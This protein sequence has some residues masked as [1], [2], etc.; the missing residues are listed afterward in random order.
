MVFRQQ[1]AAIAAWHRA[2]RHVPRGSFSLPDLRATR[3]A[4]AIT[5]VGVLVYQGVTTAEIDEPV[6]QLALGLDADVVHIAPTLD[7][8]VGVEPVRTV[9]V[10]VTSDD[11]VALRS[12]VLVIPGGLGWE[13]LVDDLSLMTWLERASKAAPGVL[14]IST[15][16]LILGS[17]GRLVGHAATGHWLA[18]DALSALGA[19]VKDERTAQ[20]DDQRI[21]TASGANSA[22]AAAADLAERVRWGP[23]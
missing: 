16:S 4:G 14:A 9:H 11:P 12:D 6:R 1:R 15:G 19:D 5:Q 2:R 13:R 21:V 3:S 8:I 18:R 7:P 20:S 10:D 22:I 17:A 23:A